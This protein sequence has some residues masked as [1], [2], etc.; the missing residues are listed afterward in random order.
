MTQLELSHIARQLTLAFAFP[1]SVCSC[2]QVNQLCKAA[3]AIGDTNLL[4]RLQEGQKKMKK[5][6][7]FAGSLYI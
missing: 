7:A 6:I 1:L 5:G 3:L 4:S 2:P